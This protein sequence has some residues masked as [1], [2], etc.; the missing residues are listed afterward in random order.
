MELELSHA[1][2]AAFQDMEAWYHL[3]QTNFNWR[4]AAQKEVDAVQAAFDAGT[5]TLDLLLRAQ[6]SRADAETAYYQALQQYNQAVAH[7]HYRKGSLLA[8]NGV[9]LAEGPWPDKAYFDAL[10]HARRRDASHYL[11]YGYTRPRV[12]SRGPVAQMDQ[13]ATSTPAEPQPRPTPAGPV[14]QRQPLEEVPEAIDMPPVPEPS[15]YDT[16]DV[17]SLAPAET[18]T[19]PE[20]PE[21]APPKLMRIERTGA[22][23]KAPAGGNRE[24]GFDLDAAHW[25]VEPAAT[26]AGQPSGH[27]TPASHKSLP[28]AS[29]KPAPDRPAGRTAI[30]LQPRP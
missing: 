22:G 29:G 17:P 19:L 3:M 6:Q 23:L 13:A 16:G 1:L 8:Y 9:Q 12:I 15:D 11:N 10:G 24:D 5:V 7:I 27:V 14:E 28:K 2:T 18:A 26:P 4:V 30:R 20:G 25:R 21:L